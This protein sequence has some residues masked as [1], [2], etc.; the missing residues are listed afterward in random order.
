MGLTQRLL[1]AVSLAVLA[2]GNFLDPA[3]FHQQFCKWTLILSCLVN[4]VSFKA[5]VLNLSPAKRE[6][7]TLRRA[8]NSPFIELWP[9]LLAIITEPS[10]CD[11]NEL[12]EATFR[13]LEQAVSAQQIDLVSV[14][15]HR[16]SEGALNE[17]NAR[18]VELCRRLMELKEI[19]E[20]F[21]VVASSD[22]VDAGVEAKVD[23][24]HVKEAQWPDLVPEIRRKAEAVGRNSSTLILG[25]SIHS[26]QA[27]ERAIGAKLPP[28]YLFVGTCYK[29]VSHPGKTMLEGPTL[30]GKVCRRL[31]S[32]MGKNRP[33]IFAIGG[34]NIANCD[35]PVRKYGADGV[36]VIRAI[37]NSKDPALAAKQLKARMSNKPGQNDS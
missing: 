30:P 9:P 14:R 25:T 27:A 12:M 6:M 19:H 17:Q 24:F 4:A 32:L 16:L 29:T 15:V 20:G 10:A 22:W 35:E 1:F 31:A 18:V 23:G 11:T 36:A 7:E 21:L 2:L 37:S 13:V 5:R 34:I 28:D 3:M 33:K 26:I 8:V